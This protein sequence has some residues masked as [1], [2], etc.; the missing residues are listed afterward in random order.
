MQLH[1]NTIILFVK[2]VNRLKQFYAGIL[3]FEVTE[4]IEPGWVLLKTG[5][6]SIGLHEAGAAYQPASGEDSNTKLVFDTDGDLYALRERLIQQGVTVREIKSFP[7]YNYILFDGE[8][9]EGNVFQIR[10]ARQ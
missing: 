8:D 1:L 9:P 10:Q 7:G 4:T 2:D 5:G 6:C 3:G